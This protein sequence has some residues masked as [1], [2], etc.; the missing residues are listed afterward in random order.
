MAARGNGGGN[1]NRSS[2]GGDDGWGCLLG[3]FE[4][5]FAL[6]VFLFCTGDKTCRAI[7]WGIVGFL[8][9]IWILAEVGFTADEM[10]GLFGA[11]LRLIVVV[12]VVGGLVYLIVRNRNH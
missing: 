12:V 2:G 9:L 10:I 7:A 8:A 1:R 5:I 6:I 3:V 11:A 4:L